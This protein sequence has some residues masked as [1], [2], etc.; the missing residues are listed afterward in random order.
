MVPSDAPFLHHEFLCALERTDCV[1][2]DSGWIPQHILLYEDEST[3]A[4]PL[5]AVPLYLKSH[6]WGEYVFDWAWADAY[7]RIGLSYYPK[8]VAAV[9]FTP[10][11]GPRLLARPD[12][13]ADSVKDSL[14]S[15]AL[16]LARKLEVSSLHWLFT[17][18]ED[19]ERLYR[20]GLQRRVGSQFH[21]RNRQYRTFDDYLQAF[22]SHKRKKIKRERRRVRDA[23]IEVRV[24]TGKDITEHHWESFHRFYHSTVRNHGAIAYLSREF[25]FELGRSMPEKVV[26][27]LASKDGDFVAGTL[28][29]R[30]S[31]SLYGRYWGADRWFADLHFELCYYRSIEYCISEGLQRFEAGAQGEHKLTRG[32]LPT[33]TYSAHW[34]SHPEFSAAVAEY[35]TREQRGVAQYIDALRANSPFRAEL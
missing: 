25:F 14:I 8:L 5:G 7:R 29:L 27:F 6:S 4:R 10:V 34:L 16:M 28:N 32:L 9:P 20:H 3:A 12:V 1:G 2:A 33:P 21:W 24:F 26:M 18:Q 31:H 30:G 11:T 22:A 23:G 35:L 19:T 17:C 13:D 15:A